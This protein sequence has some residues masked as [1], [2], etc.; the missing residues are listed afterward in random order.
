MRLVSACFASVVYGELVLVE[1]SQV[2]F[3][4]LSWVMVR[5]LKATSLAIYD[6]TVLVLVPSEKRFCLGYDRTPNLCF[7]L[8]L[9]WMRAI[10]HCMPSFRTTREWTD[11]ATRIAFFVFSS[12]MD[13]IQV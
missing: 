11:N 12:L 3:V 1:F 9:L 2:A 10:M 4:H 6:W 5:F 7:V 8:I 13:R